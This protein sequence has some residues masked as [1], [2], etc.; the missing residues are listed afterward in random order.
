MRLL[1]FSNND[2]SEE[3]V[4]FTTSDKAEDKDW[5]R[6]GCTLDEVFEIPDDGQPW[7]RLPA[8]EELSKS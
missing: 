4:V 1:L 3:Y 8:E 6:K 2:G 5:A 7:H